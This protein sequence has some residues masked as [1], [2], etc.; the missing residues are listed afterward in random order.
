MLALAGTLQA[1]TINLAWDPN[2]EAD[3]G[4]YVILFGMQPA[5]YTNQ[6]DVGNL[7]SW[8][9]TGL[10][11]GETYYFA[12]RAYNSFGLMSPL[13]N[14]VSARADRAPTLTGPSDRS[15]AE[16]AV[17]SL[18]LAASDLDGDA[19]TYSATGL[20]AALSVN[21]TTGLIS[22]E[23]AYT[24]A[25][26]YVVMVTVSDGSLSTS[27]TFTWTV[28]HANR[29]PTL[30]SPGDQTSAEGAVVA[31]L[32]EA[33]DLNEDALT[34]RATGLPPGLSVD[35]ATGLIAGTLSYTSAGSH[36]VTATVSDGT[37]SATETFTWTVTNINRAPTL[38]NLGDQTSAEGAILSLALAA[39]DP[40]GNALTYSTTGPP[41]GLSIDPATGLLS[42][43]LAYTSAG[44]HTVTMTASDGDLSSSATFT[45]TVTNTNRVPT[46]TSPGDRTNAEGETIALTLPASDPDGDVL[47]FSTSGLPAGLSIDP[48]TGLISGTLTSTNAGV[49]RVTGTVADGTLSSSQTF[50]W[51]VT[52]TV[53]NTVTS[54]NRVPTLTSPGDRTDSEGDV[55][56]L[57]LAASDPD[58]DTL[59]FSATE[60]PAGLSINPA[61]GLISGTLADTSAGTYS[62]SAAVSDGS[63]S[64]SQS[65]IW[66]IEKITAG[67]VSYVTVT[68]MTAN[69]VVDQ[70]MM[71]M[72]EAFDAANNPVS[73]V[74]FDWTTVDTT[75]VDLSA[76][77]G[78]S[79]TITT[80][81][82]GSATIMA[83]TGSGRYSATST[84][85]VTATP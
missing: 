79:I 72:A 51:T 6:I 26:A 50:T 45:W 37:L 29:A 82:V 35:P 42:G 1:E 61:T 13:S 53:P 25:G 47:T 60:L 66:T 27:A 49:Y 57:A 36:Q 73:G 44:T 43:T 80:R 63:A 20:P 23:L 33:S 76:T 39:S 70:S 54:T 58:S 8:A 21:P 46:L 67:E 31:L 56:S 10:A 55:L 7:T 24:T 84:V 59:M 22:G 32:L 14:V 2:S 83:T 62:V 17:P 74:T 48:A 41:A 15:D 71:L 65:F 34:Y 77:T 3:V 11:G 78:T 64:V 4:G 81:A 28:I 19:L 75:V 69:L 40:D 68:P 38:T 16:G 12:V 5:V 30:R 9:V 52:N 18:A 85:Q